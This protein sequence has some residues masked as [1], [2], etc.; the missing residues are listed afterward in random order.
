MD[1]KT[2]TADEKLALVRAINGIEPVYRFNPDESIVETLPLSFYPFG[3]LVSITKPLPVQ[4]LLWYVRLPSETVSLDG[5]VANIN[6]LND[7][8]PISLDAQN[9]SDYLKFR[10][11]FAGKMWLESA[12]AVQSEN[13]F[14]VTARVLEKDGQ[15]E[16][17]FTVAK[18][19]D[20]TL[21]SKKKTGDGK[22]PPDRFSF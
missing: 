22:R 16:K 20:L 15:F 8:A 4:P 3:I 10:L 19:G 2:A 5:S 17:K 6:Y 9:I 18:N 1:W 21:Q 14:S 12:L 7:K 13:G 11:Y